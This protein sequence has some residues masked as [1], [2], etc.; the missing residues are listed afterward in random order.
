MKP[1]I[2]LVPAR[3]ATSGALEAA[4]SRPGSSRNAEAACAGRQ[5]RVGPWEA[6]SRSGK[7]QLSHELVSGDRAIVERES[8]ETMPVLTVY[9]L[10]GGR[11]RLTHYCVEGNQAR[12]PAKAFNPDSGELDF[13]FL[14]AL[15]LASPGAGHMQHAKIRIVDSSHLVSEWQFYE[16]GKQKFSETAQYTRVR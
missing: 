8:S 10:D 13:Q 4:D 11:L 3:I 5:T 1:Q 2:F 9:D 12:R 15:N 7:L 14:D 6:N 16:N